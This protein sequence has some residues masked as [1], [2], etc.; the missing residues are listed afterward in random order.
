MTNAKILS[1]T[2]TYGVQLI[3]VRDYEILRVADGEHE[4]KF[5]LSINFIDGTNKQIM[6]TEEK[7]ANPNDLLNLIARLNDEPEFLPPP[8]PVPAEAPKTNT[9]P[10]R[11]G[12]KRS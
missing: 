12:G 7:G 3:N 6:S 9:R 8:P 4:E 10:A 5:L 11:R 1:L 2:A